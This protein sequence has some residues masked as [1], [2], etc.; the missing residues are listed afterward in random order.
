VA[1]QTEGNEGNED[2]T[3]GA[4]SS[5]PGV[6]ECADMSA[7]SNATGSAA[8]TKRRHIAA[9]QNRTARFL[10]LVAK[11][12]AVVFCGQSRPGGLSATDSARS[13]HRPPEGEASH[14]CCSHAPAGRH[15][16]ALHRCTGNGAQRRRY[17]GIYEIDHDKSAKTPFVRPKS[18]ADRQLNL[19]PCKGRACAPIDGSI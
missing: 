5:A 9:L 17:S 14:K 1:N 12:F 7:L 2:Q 4:M 6:L 11:G 15:D 13:A 8:R 16:R 3:R 10:G 19:K 18:R